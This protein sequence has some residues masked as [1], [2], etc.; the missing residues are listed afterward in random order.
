M[1]VSVIALLRRAH[2][3]IDHDA[4]TVVAVATAS[5]QASVLVLSGGKDQT[6]KRSAPAI[7]V[8]DAAWQRP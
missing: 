5:C 4:S 8:I 7:T 6:L 1:V 2:L 3:I